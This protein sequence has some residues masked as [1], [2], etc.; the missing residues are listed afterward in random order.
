M[1]KK[2]LLVA[3]L[4]K[5]N[6]K[7]LTYETSGISPKTVRTFAGQITFSPEVVRDGFIA[8]AAK[9]ASQLKMALSQKDTL[10]APTEVML[11]LSSDKT[12]VKTLSSQDSPDGFIRTLPYFKEEL[13]ITSE[14]KKTK[15]TSRTTY[16]AFEKKL[17]EDFQRPF[18]D[19][20]KIVIGVKSQAASLAGKYPQT[21]RYFLLA[22][23]EKEIVVSVC[24]DGE[25]LELAAFKNDVFANQFSDFIGSHNLTDIKRA[26]TVG[27]FPQIALEKIRSLGWEIVSLD[28]TDI[29][30]LM[31]TS[32]LKNPRLGMPS[33]PTVALPQFSQKYLFLAGAALVGVAL[34]IMVVRGLPALLNKNKELAKKPP[35]EVKP[36]PVPVPQPKPSD[37]TLRILN[38]TLVTGEAGR[39]ADALKAKGFDIAE[40]KNAT[41]AGFVATRIRPSKSVPD[42]I[43]AEIKTTLL[44][45]YKSTSLEPIPDASVSGKLL[46]EIIIGEKKS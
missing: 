41:T 1:G 37:Y 13:L 31:V 33:L 23:L 29:Y 40:T 46:I 7:L 35:V 24:E 25:V 27:N 9:F 45:T 30:D 21:G 18:L 42:K 6:L 36:E 3:F 38:G 12:F 28:S 11:F 26:Y 5:D 4:E 16:V 32:N 8:D 10:A 43:V 22:P 34:V 19:M 17:V 15:E 2:K 44:D 14:V 20:G 39:A